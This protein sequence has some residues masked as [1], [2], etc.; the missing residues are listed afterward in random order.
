MSQPLVSAM[1]DHLPLTANW[2]QVV[3]GVL[4]LRRMTRA[5]P[6]P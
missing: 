6:A 3:D 2:P 4:Y 5:D 1:V